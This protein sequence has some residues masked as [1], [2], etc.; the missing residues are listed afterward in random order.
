MVCFFLGETISQ[1][2]GLP[3]PGSLLGL[4]ML[5]GGLLSGLVKLERVEQTANFLIQHLALLLVPLSV[6]IMIEWK[7][8]S[9]DL[10]AIFISVMVSTFLVMG[11]TAK[12]MEALQERV[13]KHETGNN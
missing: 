2:S 9:R 6:A 3:F 10:P 1:Y 7:L 12:I 13:K 11:V 4:L 8:F 5:L